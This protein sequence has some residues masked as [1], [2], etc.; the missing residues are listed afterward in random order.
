VPLPALR[1]D[2]RGWMGL[3][4][5]EREHLSRRNFYRIVARFGRRRDLAVGSS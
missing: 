1:Q 5:A 2:Q 4:E 3:P